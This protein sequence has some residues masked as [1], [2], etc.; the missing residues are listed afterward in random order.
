MDVSYFITHR[1]YIYLLVYANV[2]YNLVINLILKEIYF[3]ILIFSEGLTFLSYFFLNKNTQLF[4][5]E[6]YI[7]CKT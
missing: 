7:I 4:I 1:A 6:M 5:E 3:Y 2:N